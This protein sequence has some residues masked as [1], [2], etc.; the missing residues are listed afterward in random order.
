MKEVEKAYHYAI[1]N[2]GIEDNGDEDLWI[3]AMS[4][5]NHSSINPG[6]YNEMIMG[7]AV[8]LYPNDIAKQQEF[9]RENIYNDQYSWNWKSE[10]NRAI[11]RSYLFDETNYQEL[12][13]TIAGAFVINRILSGINAARV[14][15]KNARLQTNVSVR[16]D[17]T[18]MFSFQYS[19]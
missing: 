7:Q 17:N 15:K 3:E 9:I 12:A 10:E 16:S 1:A 8:E 14:T 11:F 2:A 13:K 5:Y 19:F 6:G 4:K 18:P